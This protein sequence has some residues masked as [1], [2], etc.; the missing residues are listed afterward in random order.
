M[1]VSSHYQVNGTVFYTKAVQCTLQYIL[2]CWQ[3]CSNALHAASTH[4][5]GSNWDPG[6]PSPTHP[7]KMQWLITSWSDTSPTTRR[8]DSPVTWS[9]KQWVS[10]KAQQIWAYAV[11]THKNA[12]LHT[13]DI[14]IFFPINNLSLGNWLMLFAHVWV[15]WITMVSP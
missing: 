14:R 15:F 4:N 13:A 10:Q 11:A 5:L 1:E 8:A 3:L 12:L 6:C 2:D 9:L 7:K